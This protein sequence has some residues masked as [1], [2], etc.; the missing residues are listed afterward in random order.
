MLFGVIGDI[1]GNIEALTAMHDRL[2]SIG[3]DVIIALGD[4][5]G[6]GAS[7]RECI[8]FAE[9]NDIRCIRGNHDHF[10]LDTEEQLCWELK[11]YAREAILWTQA[12]LSKEHFDWLRDLPF[13]MKI[14]GMQFVHASSETVDGEYWPYIL[15]RKTAQFHFY[16]QETPV[17]FCGHIHIPLLFTQHNGEIIM[18]MLK[19]K[20]LDLKS[21]R[22]YL[23]NPG[24]VGQP[25]D[26]DWR[27]AAATFDNETGMLT[28]VRVEYD[29]KSAQQKI[30]DAGLPEVLA[31]RLSRGY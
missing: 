22:R 31:N 27:A 10:T 14:D 15:D 13:S 28:P 5:V 6:Y 1:H 4:I 11:D 29:L 26:S 3:C 19:E 21:K 23:I 30:L 17:A 8:D 9:A 7:P 25:R 24:A 2:V 16:L 20:Q 12:N 18:E